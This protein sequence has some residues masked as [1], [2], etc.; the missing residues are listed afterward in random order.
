MAT[1]SI[2][3]DAF[4]PKSS[5]YI[6]REKQHNK[7]DGTLGFKILPNGSKDAYFIYYIDGKEKLRKIGR[8]GKTKGL[9]SLKS[10]RDTYNTLSREYQGGIDIK[11]QALLK[12]AT[13]EKEKKDIADAKLKKEMQ[14]SFQQLVT[15]YLEYVEFK[16][17]KKHHNA[18]NKAFRLNLESF[19]RTKKAS[20][21]TKDDI[22]NIINPITLRGSLIASNRMRSYLSAMFSWGI[23]FDDDVSINKTNIKFYITNNPVTSVKKPLKKEPPAERFLSKSE[24]YNFWLAL[25]KNGMSIYRKNILKLMIAIGARVESLSMLKWSEIDW[26]ERLITIPPARSKN[27]NHWVIPLGDIAYDILKNNPKTNDIFLFPAK[28]GDAIQEDTV[29]K[30]T[31]RVCEQ[32]SLEHFSPRD[33]RRT[34]KT[35]SGMAGIDKSIRDKIQ[36]HSDKD[37]S[38]IHYD[39]YDYLKEKRA[40]IEVWND[41]LK[42]I[43]E[44]ETAE[45]EE[46]V[47]N[48]ERFYI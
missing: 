37:I 27:G 5:P 21:V 7:K 23:D 19:D 45:A 12:T 16:L 31:T 40:A 4:K 22:S 44:G 46:E 20:D 8:Y 1:T 33:L 11:E 13:L 2:E 6:I 14:G 41:Y 32:N 48:L 36:N 42:T 34:W 43:L 25:D 26:Q 28:N 10:I 29:G 9:M 35:I 17:S 15:L 3:L 39:R 47:N 38:S 24:I 18:M 30:A